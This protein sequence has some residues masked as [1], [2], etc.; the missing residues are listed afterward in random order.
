MVMQMERGGARK[1]GGSRGCGV[2]GAVLGRRFVHPESSEEPWTPVLLWN[3]LGTHSE[4]SPLA[5]IDPPYEMV[6]FKV[7]FPLDSSL[8]LCYLHLKEFFIG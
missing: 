1:H 3:Q 5:W 7:S 8:K 2:A 6:Q 4:E